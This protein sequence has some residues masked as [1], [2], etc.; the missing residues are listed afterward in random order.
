MTTKT[1]EYPA[2]VLGFVRLPGEDDVSAVVCTSTTALAWNKHMRDF[3]SHFKLGGEIDWDY[4]TVPVSFIVHP[5][6]VL[7]DYGNDNSQ[8]FCVLPQRTWLDYFSNLINEINPSCTDEGNVDRNSDNSTLLKTN[9][10]NNSASDSAYCGPDVLDKADEESNLDVAVL[11]VT[12]DDDSS[13]SSVIGHD[14]VDDTDL[15]L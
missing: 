15:L 5:L 11:L 14:F 6:F 2:L 13:C 7:Q 1:Y 12:D 3:V 10:S 4:N 8:S 9:D